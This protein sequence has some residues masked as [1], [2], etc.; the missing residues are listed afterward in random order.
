MNDWYIILLDALSNRF[1]NKF[2]NNTKRESKSQLMSASHRTG[3][4]MCRIINSDNDTAQL[5]SNILT[6]STSWI[7]VI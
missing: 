7:I 4:P 3:V 5:P 6:N 2:R 1:R